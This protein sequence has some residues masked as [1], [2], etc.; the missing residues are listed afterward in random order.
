MFECHVARSTFGGLKL[1]HATG[2]NFEPNNFSNMDSG[3]LVQK[4]FSMPRKGHG[5]AM[6]KLH[7][8]ETNSNFL[9]QLAVMRNIH[10]TT[11]VP[12]NLEF[13]FPLFLKSQSWQIANERSLFACSTHQFRLISVDMSH[14]IPNSNFIQRRVEI[15]HANHI[16]FL[17]E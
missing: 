11:I 2:P 17:L 4:L 16:Q 7:T 8:S 6:A 14:L 10:G 9:R 1:S 15:L 5:N 3:W 12:L 13:R